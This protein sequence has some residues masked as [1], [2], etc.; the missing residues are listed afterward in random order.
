MRRIYGRDREED[1]RQPRDRSFKRPKTQQT[2]GDRS[3]ADG[4][5]RE[6]VVSNIIHLNTD[7]NA[8]FYIFLAKVILH[9]HD[10]TEVELHASGDRNVSSAVRVTD[11]LV[12]YKYVTISR[13]KTKLI[14]S[15][16]GSK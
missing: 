13:M 14:T 2:A 7:R 1:R 10:F 5:K 3:T 4:T 9:N 8:N 15:R 11:V 6:R 16:E 12:R